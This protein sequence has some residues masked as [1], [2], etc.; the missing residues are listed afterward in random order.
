MTGMGLQADKAWAQIIAALLFKPTEHLQKNKQAA[1]RHASLP[2][3]NARS[4]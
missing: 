3:F 2:D 1:M 4:V